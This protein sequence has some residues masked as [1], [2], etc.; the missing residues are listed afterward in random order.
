[1]PIHKSPM[2]PSPN[3]KACVVHLVDRLCSLGGT[4]EAITNMATAARRHGYS[5]AVISYDEF[6][7][8]NQYADQLERNDIRVFCPPYLRM[9]LYKL[10]LRLCAVVLFPLTLLLCSLK[11]RQ[12]PWAAWQLAL[13]E[14]RYET[15]GH[16]LASMRDQ[17]LQHTLETLYGSERLDLLHVHSLNPA[18]LFGLRWA[19]ARGLPAIWHEH[20]DLSAG[21]YRYYGERY[22]EET[23]RL[24]SEQAALVTQIRDAEALGSLGPSAQTAIIPNWIEDLDARPPSYVSGPLV[25]GSLSRLV[26]GKGLEELIAALQRLQNRGVG[27]RCRL[28]G[29]GPLMPSLK[30]LAVEAGCQGN[31]EFLGPLHHSQIA[32]FLSSIDVF[33]LPSHSEAMPMS[34]LQA[35]SASRPILATPV[36]AVPDLVQEGVNGFLVPVGNVEALT[37]RLCELASQPD[38]VQRMGQASRELY[39]ANYTEEAA[40]PK[41]SALYDRLTANSRLSS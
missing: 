40:W 12:A 38:L 19:F 29:S 24:V 26:E 3:H 17:R 34:I 30:R 20:R 6:P 33:V 4:E 10:L 11:R 13:R 16:R 35:L 25:V 18:T 21:R 37:E 28:A 41:L 23:V 9:S 27:F 39:L 14:V 22:G 5:V 8:P 32:E 31:L 15:V 2:N 1:M 7:F 36:G